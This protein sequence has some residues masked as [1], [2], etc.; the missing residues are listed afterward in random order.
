MKG[1]AWR[2][3]AGLGALGL[4]IGLWAVAPVEAWVRDFNAWIGDLGA[5][6]WVLFGLA[7]VVATVALLPGSVLTLAAGLAFGLWAFPLV[8]VAAALG[9][10]LAF[11]IGRYL[12][13]EAVSRRMADYPRFRAVDQAV[14]QEGWKIV[15]LMR[16]SPLVPFNLQNYLFGLTDVRFWH[17]AW[18]TFFGIMPGTLLYVYFGAAGRAA[19]GQAVAEEGSGD[20]LRNV[21]LAVGLIATLAVTVIVTRT[22][23]RRLAMLEELDGS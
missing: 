5:L 9:A 12:A 18:A 2:W 4:I 14:A 13:R 17:Y 20:L 21:L 1:N 19:L 8:V 11:L 3:I 6:G 16:L 10:W 7:Y 22:A 15:G 23:K